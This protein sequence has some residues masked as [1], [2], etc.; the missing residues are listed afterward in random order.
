[1]RLTIVL[2]IVYLAILKLTN[3]GYRSP[4]PSPPRAGIV[5][6]SVVP[7]PGESS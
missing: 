4:A 5:W 6:G 2:G 7:R 1:M 3:A